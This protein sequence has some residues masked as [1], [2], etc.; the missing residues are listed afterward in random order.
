VPSDLEADLALARRLGDVADQ[1]AMPY[2]RTDVRREWKGDGSPVTEADLAVERA[3]LDILSAERP[4]DAILS[5]ESGASGLAVRRRW[6]IDPIDGTDYFLAGVTDWGAHV[7]L[8][9]DGEIVVGLISRPAERRSWW[10]TKDGGAWSS[11]GRRLQVT[12]T[13]ALDGARV[14]GYVV[15]GSPW[16]AAVSARATWVDSQSPILEL[17]EGRVDA[18]LS[19]GGFEWDHA[20]AVVLVHEAGGRFTDPEGGS[21]IALRGGLYSNG[22]FDGELWAARPAT[23]RDA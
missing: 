3:L 14:A 17:L 19:E 16:G 18:V 6:L 13:P 20:P 10:A 4:D 21:G 15:R 9:V 2:F 7:A 23:R 1:V 12:T 22:R 11:D 8:E 5:E